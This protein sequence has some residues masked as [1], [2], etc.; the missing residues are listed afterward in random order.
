M[1]EKILEILNKNVFA[2]FYLKYNPE[3]HKDD[4]IY[5]PK[6]TGIDPINGAKE[7]TSHVFEFIEW[8]DKYAGIPN[9]KGSYLYWED[10]FN[11]NELYKHWLTNIKDK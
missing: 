10:H 3:K 4:A 11:L 5:D 8:K 6:L 9:K 1:E 7:I 2:G